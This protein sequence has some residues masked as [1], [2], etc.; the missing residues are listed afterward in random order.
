MMRARWLVTLF[1]VF[2]LAATARPAVAQQKGPA[3][4]NSDAVVRIANASP[5][6][7]LDPH[8]A[9]TPALAVF[10]NLIYDRLT[11]IDDQGR[12][13]PMLAT[14]WTPTPDGSA[15]VF[16]L[17][18]DVRFHDGTPFDAAAVKA[19]IERGKTISGSTASGALQVITAVEIV[20]PYT[21]RMRLAQGLGA[22]VPAVLA[23]QAGMM[24]SPK[25]MADAG[26]NLMLNPGDAGSAPYMV[27]EFEP[28]SKI[29]FERAPGKHWEPDAA[30]ARRIE[31]TFVQLASA[32]LNS[33]RAGQ[34]DLAQIV[35][36]DITQAQQVVAASNGALHGIASFPANTQ[37]LY[38][39]GDRVPDPRIRTAIQFAIDRNA[40]ANGLLKGICAETEQPYP[41]SHW[42]YVPDFAKIPHDPARAR[43][44]LKDAGAADF[45]LEILTS[46]GSS[47]EPVAQVIQSQLGEVG[48]KATIATA[49]TADAIASFYRGEKDAFVNILQALPDPSTTV[50]EVLLSR[51]KVVPP[52]PASDFNQV[53]GLAQNALNP[54]LKQAERAQMYAQIWK[55]NAERAYVI[56]ICFT[57][58]Y[59]VTA[60]K[61]GGADGVLAASTLQGA[62][63]DWRYVFVNP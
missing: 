37:A 53:K 15:W 50:N 26:R 35:G 57:E 2:G 39:R 42:A 49:P 21:V 34:F 28:R 25:A 38:I 5:P 32:R 16:K 4:W 7:G 58:Q 18:R 45:K 23:T 43:A 54:K 13:A 19:S 31:I 36:N 47:S 40:I 24:I 60:S 59:W 12:V 1:L 55:L 29:F 41:R 30:K 22:D 3:R 6:I 48:I 56:P 10:T 27:A 9:L 20:D 61:V 33:I 8:R 51:Y 17:R 44:L 52:V 63:T 11:R 14:S 62:I 46:A